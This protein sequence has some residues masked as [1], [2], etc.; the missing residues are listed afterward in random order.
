MCLSALATCLILATLPLLW[1]P[2]LPALPVIQAMIIAG[3]LLAF[4]RHKI[5]R[6]M[7]FWLLFFAWGGL[8]AL[9]EVWPMQHLTSGPQKAELEI[10]ATRGETMYQARIV[11]LNGRAILPAVGVTLYGN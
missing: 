9:N 1:L 7:G 10:L 4:I 3:L 11:R 5:A 8:A 2:T 6:W